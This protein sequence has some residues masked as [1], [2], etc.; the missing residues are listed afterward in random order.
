MLFEDA[1]P[2]VMLVYHKPNYPHSDDPPLSLFSEAI[3]GSRISPLY[4]TLVAK[5]KILTS[6]SNFEVP[7]YAYPNLMVF[8]LVP[9][10]DYTNQEAIVA[11][12]TE[13][14]KIIEKGL[15]AKDI[16][17]ARRSLLTAYL[18]RMQ[19]N[20]SLARDFA[21]SEH[22]YGNWSAFLDWQEDVEKVTEEDLKRV[23]KM[24]FKTT[25]RTVAEVRKKEKGGQK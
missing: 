8:E 5:K 6:L 16:R 2:R 12:D 19:S 17:I 21:S 9:H 25:N 3:S 23:S 15:Q 18:G 24:Y 10:S 7:G 1:S 20:L 22:L 4:K 13:L 11:F 14:R